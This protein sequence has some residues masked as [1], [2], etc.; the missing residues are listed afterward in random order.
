MG[1]P[2]SSAAYYLFLA[3]MNGCAA[4]YAWLRKRS[5]RAGIGVAAVFALVFI[6]LSPLAMSGSQETMPGLPK[7][8]SRDFVNWATGPVVYSGGATLM[9]IILF[10]FRRFFVNPVVAWTLLNA[11]LFL[12]G[13]SIT[14]QD[15]AEIVTKPDNVPIVGLVYLLGFF[16]WLATSLKRLKTTIELPQGLPPKEKDDN[17]KILVWPDLVYTELICMV[18]LTAF[19]IVWAILPQSTIRRAGQQREDAQ[20]FQ[21]RHGTSSVCRKCWSILILGMLASCCRASW[22]VGLMAIPYL[23][24]Q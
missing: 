8:P 16:T 19:L 12:M 7:W 18:A 10:V 24:F 4:L 14:N 3:A 23:G 21:R 22:L 9:L 17:E 13:L 1:L 5:W 15:F 11:V 2:G 6:I 20:P